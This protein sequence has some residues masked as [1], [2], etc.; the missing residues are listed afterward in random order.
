VL[1]MV[2]GMSWT[3]SEGKQERR[4]SIIIRY[5]AHVFILQIYQ[6]E[7]GHCLDAVFPS[8]VTCSDVPKMCGQLA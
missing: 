4:R 1:L 5:H 6:Q 8:T 2:R 3:R 7:P